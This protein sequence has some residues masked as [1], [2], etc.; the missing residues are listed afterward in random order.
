M[1]KPRQ[2]QGGSGPDNIRGDVKPP[3]YEAPPQRP[4]P[5]PKPPKKK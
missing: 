2:D 3:S 1:K 5:T 4:K